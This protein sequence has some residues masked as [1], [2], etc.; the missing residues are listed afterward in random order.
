MLSKKHVLAAAAASVIALG[1]TTL[2]AA[3]LMSHSSGA[4]TAN[5]HGTTQVHYKRHRTHLR[6]QQLS[7]A[8]SPFDAPAAVDASLASPIHPLSRP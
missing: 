4:R 8:W 7:R 3:P 2:S 6:T 5:S 1:T